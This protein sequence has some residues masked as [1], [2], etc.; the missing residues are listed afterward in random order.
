MDVFFDTD[1]ASQKD[2]DGTDIKQV[3]GEVGRVRTFVQ[4]ILTATQF[5]ISPKIYLMSKIRFDRYI[6][7]LGKTH[8]S[9]LVE[10]FGIS[11]HQLKSP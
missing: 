10:I 6:F 5:F 1:S 8:L 9:N 3:V 7:S 2:A 11:F 4:T